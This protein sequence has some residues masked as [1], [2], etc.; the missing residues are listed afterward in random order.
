MARHLYS[1][2]WWLASPLLPLRLW[3]RGRREP[4]YRV[5][6]G[7]RFGRYADKA[8]APRRD[9]LWIHAVSLGETRAAAPLIE[10]IAREHPQTD[11][12]LTAMT[13]SGREA[14]RSLYGDRVLQVWLPYDLPFAVE[15]FL[16]RFRPRAGLLL[17]TEL[18]PNLI[19]ACSRRGIPVH[20]VNARM[21]ERSA[22]RYARMSALTRPMLRAIA[23]VAAQTD[24]DAKRLD[25]LGAHDIAVTGNLKFDLDVS[26]AMLARGA[27]LRETLGR[28]RSVWLAASTREGEEALLLD[29]IARSSRFDALLLLVPRHPQRFDDVEALVRARGL[30]VVRRTAGNPVTEDTRVVLGDTMGEMLAYCAA[31]DIAFV[32]GSLLPL[33]G[34]NL[35]EPIAV[36][37]PTLVGPHTFNF[38]EVTERAIEAGATLRV[39]N[40]DALLATVDSLLS[41]AQRR[42]EMRKAALDFVTEHRGATE[43]LWHWLDPKLPRTRLSSEPS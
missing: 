42:A 29:A 34:Q 21:S 2:L 16:D 6:I 37:V 22:A 41:D 26:Q 32:G 30:A 35:I 13:A 19:H 3:W 14:G 36:G 5:A 39:P 15:A 20:L 11:I 1:L 25:D 40:A 33:G 8:P 4:G 17:E 27:A 28:E 24:A 23:S 31:A 7:E 18:W 10:R 38:A 43:R 12:V 9:V